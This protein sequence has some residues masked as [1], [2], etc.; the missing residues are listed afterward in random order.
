[1]FFWFTILVTIGGLAYAGLLGLTYI[2][3]S[4]AEHE[5]LKLSS[6]GRYASTYSASFFV[7]LI[8]IFVSFDNRVS[9]D[10]ALPNAITSSLS[11]KE[12]SENATKKRIPK[13][14]RNNQSSTI[15]ASLA[16]ILLVFTTSSQRL[17]PLTKQAQPN[18]VYIKARQTYAGDVKWI[19]THT[20]AGA[21]I[22]IAVSSQ[23]SFTS[24]IFNYL[25]LNH[26]YFSGVNFFEGYGWEI[27][28]RP[29]DAEYLYV[30]D[31]NQ[32]ELR[33]FI[34]SFSEGKRKLVA[35]NGDLYKIVDL[36]AH[37]VKKIGYNPNAVSK[38]VR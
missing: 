16:I 30:L 31:A 3:G 5:V 10:S 20:P 17:T 21:T 34:A 35:K 28:N 33:D 9:V 37:Q 18:N 6:F 19:D 23:H 36:E 32:S 14:L 27:V 24:F 26:K 29:S 8:F 7:A 38:L 22:L 4:F 2:S 15:I 12:I 11:P 1:M 25:S 13:I